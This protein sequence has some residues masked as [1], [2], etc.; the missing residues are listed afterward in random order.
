METKKTHWRKLTNKEFIVGEMLDGKEVTLVIKSVA[1]EELQNK[2]GKENKPVIRFN[3]TDQKL[4][5]NVTNLKTISKVLK[6][7]FIE[8]WTGQKITL[9][10]IKGTFFGEEQ[11]VIRIKKDYSNIKV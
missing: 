1:V 11:E 3:G 4:V 9:I 2:Q 5:L 8:E 7:P 6:T 10:P